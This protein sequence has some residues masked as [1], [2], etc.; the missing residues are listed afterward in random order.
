MSEPR[1]ER[2]VASIH[3]P[4]GWRDGT[5]ERSKLPPPQNQGWPDP[6]ESG[7]VILATHRVP[8]Q[9]ITIVRRV[10]AGV[11]KFQQGKSEQQLGPGADQIQQIDQLH[12]WSE[13]SDQHNPWLGAQKTGGPGPAPTCD[14]KLELLATDGRE[15]E[16]NAPPRNG[17]VIALPPGS[18]PGEFLSKSALIER[19]WPAL[20]FGLIAYS[21]HV[22]VIGPRWIALVARWTQPPRNVLDW[23]F[24]RSWGVME[25]VDLRHD[26]EDAR[27]VLL[28]GIP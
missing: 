23:G 5:L 4:K 28:G 17:E 26:D 7:F 11:F 6:Y 25:G 3:T 8:E 20:R 27:R 14:W 9:Y 16:D 24:A 13:L 19:L 22:A 10:E 1:L 15:G 2:P 21:A 12:W 18:S